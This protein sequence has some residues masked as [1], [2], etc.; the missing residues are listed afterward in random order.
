[1]EQCGVK[2][3]RL[4]R[5]EILKKPTKSDK[6]CYCCRDSNSVYPDYKPETLPFELTSFINPFKATHELSRL[7]ALAF[8]SE[9][10]S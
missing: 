1:M 6:N 10:I 8:C 5:P 3:M 4:I 2:Q 7:E 9:F